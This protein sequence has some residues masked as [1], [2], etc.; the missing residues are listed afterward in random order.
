MVSSCA[1]ELCHMM[2]FARVYY[3][4]SSS[5]SLFLAVSMCSVCLI[6]SH[7]QAGCVSFL[8]LSFS[9]ILVF[10]HFNAG[11]AFIIKCIILIWPK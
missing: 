4:V 2:L 5:L 9:N 3:D 10:N 7:C 11:L 6:F 1:N 8:W